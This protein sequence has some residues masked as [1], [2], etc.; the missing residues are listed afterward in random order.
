MN[1]NHVLSRPPPPGLH[2]PLSRPVVAYLCRE[3]VALVYPT[4]E[5]VAKVF[6][7]SQEI[8]LQTYVGEWPPKPVTNPVFLIHSQY[9]ARH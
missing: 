7:A 3:Y 1:Q 2:T 9:T 4:K 5:L 6:V 8:L